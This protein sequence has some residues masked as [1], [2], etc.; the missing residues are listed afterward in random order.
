MKKLLWALI[1]A[2]SEAYDEWVATMVDPIT[3]GAKRVDEPER[4]KASSEQN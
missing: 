3:G 1:L 2:L 4:T